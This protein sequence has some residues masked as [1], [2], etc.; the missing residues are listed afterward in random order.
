MGVIAYQSYHGGDIDLINLS[1]GRLTVR[2]PFLSYPQRG[3]DLKIDFEL[4]YH[5]D[6]WVAVKTNCDAKGLNCTLVWQ[7]A[8]PNG[9]LNSQV[10]VNVYESGV[11]GVGASDYQT[12][13]LNPY[14]FFEIWTIG[15][16]DGTSHV[17]GGATSN[18]TCQIGNNTISNGYGTF[19]SIDGT[20][21]QM[22]A[23]SSSC[24]G[25]FQGVTIT[26]PTGVRSYGGYSR[27]DRNGNQITASG[28]IIT[29]TMG[30]QIPFPPV[31][32][33]AGN[34]N[35]TGC[36]GPLPIASAVSWTP[37]GYNGGTLSYKF[38]Y[39]NVP[40]VLPDLGGGGYNYP[41][42][43]LQSIVLPN[44]TT[45]TFV[46]SG[47]DSQGYSRGDLTQITLPTGGTIS[48]TY[49]GAVVYP[50]CLPKEIT[51]GS[52]PVGIRTVDA[53]DG[54]GPQQW[55]Y[56]LGGSQNAPT[57]TVTNPLNNDTV[58]TFTSIGTGYSCS[59]Y[60]TQTQNYQGHQSGGTLLKT[61]ATQY[62]YSSSGL[63][64]PPF[65]LSTS[66]VPTSI[67]T[68]W[69]NNQ[70]SQITKSYDSGFSYLNFP[71]GT[72][73]AIYGKVTSE[74]AYDYGAGAPGSLLR[75]TNTQYL[76]FA[77]SNYLTNNLLN[78]VS[79][80]Q[81]LDGGGTQRAYT[82]YGYD[83]SGL[84]PSNV[85]EQK[86]A[87]LAYPGNQTSVHHWLNTGTLTC[88]GG[89]SGGSN[90]NTISTVVYYDT[91]KV[92]SASDPCGHST[93][94]R[95]S[96]TYYGAFPT[97]VTNALSQ[98]TT[99]V[100][101]FNSGVLTSSTDPNQ[102]TSTYT[103]DSM[104]RLA[105]ANHPD[106][107][108]DTITRQEAVYPFTA[109]L[110]STINTSQN[111]VP[112]SVFDQLGRVVQTQLTSD[113]QGIDY[114]DKTYDALGR[115]ATVSNPYRTGTDATSSPKGTVT[116][117]SYDALGRKIKETYPDGSVLTTAY[118]GSSTLV[119][120]P[121][122]KWRRSRVNGLGQLVEVDEP[123]A[124]GATVNPNGCPGTGEPIWVTSYTNDVLGNLTQ[125]VQNGSHTRTFTYDS[126][127]RLLTSANPETGT[128]TY[129]YNADGTVLTKKDARNIT[130]SY[131]YD[132]LHRA[133][134]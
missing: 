116:T 88:P 103:Y 48:Y 17:M 132:A 2:A 128:I 42:P 33:S 70:V 15:M 8:Y 39:A 89:G 28:S 61:V 90:S 12:S 91:G 54:T 68:T 44:G 83:E 99:N 127:S 74:S 96:S 122:L 131:T 19:E 102:L 79:S 45:W 112:L 35:S 134:A 60:E 9:S 80:V 1:T 115:V 22:T 87:G 7:Q 82:S 49:N 101:D 65:T 104:W 73:T 98:S 20:G 55:T 123:N 13:P 10:G 130:T 30:R 119:T 110:T 50:E 25:G 106:N 36:T 40:I 109:T 107:G 71:A 57:I 77:N 29:D 69:P 46:Y 37:P 97:T 18:G 133:T 53:N 129:T 95:Y 43:M 92:Y 51:G 63:L 31:E 11:V 81:T 32:G 72:S 26:S 41:Q 78:L 14:G 52:S 76:A 121:T 59:P 111:K 64:N 66:V 84:Q 58:H 62:Q 75:K 93:T 108:Q 21:W 117:Y 100:Y 38:C 3:S 94:Y 16:P 6:P 118:C 5:G 85:T 24:T 86:V 47:M 124:V 114:T 27:E 56:S 34:T 67:T 23:P 120:D 126:L 105:Q 4:V 125:V 113:P